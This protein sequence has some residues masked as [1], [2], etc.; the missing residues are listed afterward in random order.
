LRDL[1]ENLGRIALADID[2]DNR[3]DVIAPLLAS[4]SDQDSIA[5]LENPEP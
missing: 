3:P 5:W 2:A 1:N 4:T